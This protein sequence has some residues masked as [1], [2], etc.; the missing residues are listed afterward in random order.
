MRWPLWLAAGA[1]LLVF[2][3]YSP[4][5]SAPFVFDDLYLPFLAPGF[6][7]QPLSSWLAGVR[8]A[9]M[10]SY[11]LNFK[12]SGT[13]PFLYH[14]SNVAFHFLGGVFVWFIVRRILERAGSPRMTNLLLAS[15][16]SLV[17]LLHPLNTEAVSYVASRSENLTVML[18]YAAFAVFLW[19]RS[20]AISWAES[21]G[22]LVLFGIACLTKEYAV[23][24]PAGLLLADYFFF[25]G[26]S[27]QG[28]RQNWRLYAP[29]VLGAAA[30]G[31]FVVS[32]LARAD[33]AGFG[34]KDL[35]W[36]D[37]FFTQC[38]AIWVYVGKF[39]LPVGLN[40]DH[41]FAIS[42]S[43]M[44]HGSVLGLGALAA[45]AVAAF[46]YRRRFPV[47]SYGFLL[48]LILLAPTSSFVPIQDVLVERRAYLPSIG[49]LLVAC[50]FLRRVKFDHI[51]TAALLAV[52]AVLAIATYQRNTVWADPISLWK[53]AA[54]K[55]PNKWRVQFQYADGL[56]RAGRCQES[57]AAFE[58]TSKIDKPDYRVMINWGH[59]LE[60]NQQFDLAAQKYQAATTLERNAQ[61][62]ALLGKVRAIQKRNEDAL[63][64]FD[65]AV[66]ID[67]RFDMTYTFRG[68]MHWQNNEI[69][70]ATADFKQA[71][72]INPYNQ[73]AQQGLGQ[74][75]ANRR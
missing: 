17:F 54:E 15:F 35:S 27:F 64:A 50:E 33:T 37:Y 63:N 60:C 51:W 45:C 48:F 9:L 67:P 46:A 6:E 36:S 42:R 28:I 49:L 8:P 71:L 53:D 70:K 40:V 69:E 22:V 30:G 73:L 62:W 4:A 25:P 75:S 29:I 52:P 19:R 61:A 66:R 31:W 38:R 74:I 44:D 34:L 47:A 57:A 13:E 11:W 5:I 20:E 7:R 39:V 16:S 3:V 12:V 18:L 1:L 32:T 55:S 43:L 59:A 24:L 26:F 58:R 23:V 41:E 72:A 68:A 21:I 14:V 10:L 56:Y 2:A 65:Q